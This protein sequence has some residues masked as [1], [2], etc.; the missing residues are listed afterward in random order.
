MPLFRNGRFVDDDWQIPVDDGPL[1]ATGKIALPKA[2]YLAERETLGRRNDAIGVVLTAGDTLDEI[3]ADLPR[4]AL[5]VIRFPKYTD[6]RPYSLARLLRDRHG[7]AGEIRATGDVLR[8]QIALM[9]RAGFDAFDV[10]H[11]GTIEALREKRIVAVRRHYQPASAE[12]S[13]TR[14]DDR[15]WRRV[16]AAFS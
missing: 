12:A 1:P 5:V 14:P 6:G 11:P 3:V 13:E 10:T 4:L 8:D 9:L 7:F 15:P 2:Q 16:S